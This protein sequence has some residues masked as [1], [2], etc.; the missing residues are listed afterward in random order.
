[1]GAKEGELGT[2]QEYGKGELEQRARRKV[3]MEHEMMR[4]GEGKMKQGHKRLPTFEAIFMLKGP[5]SLGNE[6][7]T[8]EEAKAGIKPSGEF[9]LAE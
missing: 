7:M 8:H 4:N 3:Q 6:A 1:M 9:A 5:H 2:G